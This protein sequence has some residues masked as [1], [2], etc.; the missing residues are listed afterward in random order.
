MTKITLYHANWCGHCKHFK[1]TWDSMKS[2]FDSNKIQHAEYEDSLNS[3]EIE[4]ANINGFPTIK[5]VKDGKEYEYQGKRTEEAIKK[6]L[7]NNVQSGGAVCEHGKVGSRCVSC[8]TNEKTLDERM[9]KDKYL[10][11]KYKY[12]QL[13]KEYIEKN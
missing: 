2:F 8:N 9:Y 13:K 4:A 7:I 10:K 5:I 6:E 12:L 1:P 3:K 11:Y